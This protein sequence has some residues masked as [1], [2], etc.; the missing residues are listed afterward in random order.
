MRR[1]VI[2]ASL[3]A[4]AIVI[5]GTTSYAASKYVV[6]SSKQ[7][8]D[9]SLSTADL[10]KKARVQLHGARGS[11]GPQ[12][13]QGPTG[14][15]GPVGPSH[16]YS[17]TMPASVALPA[18]TGQTLM[19]VNVPA[20]DYVVMARIQG[21]TGSDPNPGNNYRFDCSLSGPDVTF[22]DPVYRV[23]V[24]PYVER[25]LTFQGAG[26]VEQAGTITLS[27]YA[28]NGHDLSVISGQLQAIQ[29]GDLD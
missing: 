1:T 5:T 17:A 7:V 4:L 23:G 10:S 26:A 24:D 15:A 3:L 21:E 14:Q 16:A 22:D 11:A 18:S 19:T 12:G 25:Y 28:G 2:W 29:V 9:G 8:K 13:M 27:C 20:G 6:T